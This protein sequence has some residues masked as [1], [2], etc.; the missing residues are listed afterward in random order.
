[1]LVQL[2]YKE[3]WRNT[4]ITPSLWILHA[5]KYIG[6]TAI[7]TLGTVQAVLVAERSFMGAEAKLIFLFIIR[8]F[9]GRGLETPLIEEAN[10]TL[11]RLGFSHVTHSSNFEDDLEDF[12]SHTPPSRF[13]PTAA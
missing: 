5:E 9:L 2:H 11:A 4:G 3:S 1:T 10:K 8:R 12:E 6:W 7:D 13:L